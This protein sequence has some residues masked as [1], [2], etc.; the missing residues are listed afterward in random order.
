MYRTSIHWHGIRMHNNAINDGANGVTECPIPPGG[1][2]VYRFRAQQYGVTWY[3]SHYS[4][5]YANGVIGH[6]IINGPASLPFEND[7]GILSITDTYYQAADNILHRVNS[8]TDPIVP[9]APGAPPPADNL[10]F[11]GKAINYAGSGGS[12]AKLTMTRGKRHRLRLVNPSVDTSFTV[13]IVGHQMTVI[14]ADFVPVHSFT[15]QTLFLGIGQRYDVTIDASQA[16]GN[17]WI[18]AT[19]GPGPCG[20]SRNPFPAAI[21]S[22]QGAPNTLPTNRGTPPPN[23]RCEDQHGLVPVIPRNIPRGGFTG[24]TGQNIPVTL[25]TPPPGTTDPNARIVWK[26]N[27]SAIDIDWEHP[28]LELVANGDTDYPVKTNVISIPP[29][30]QVSFSVPLVCFL[31]VLTSGGAKKNSGATGSSRTKGHCRIPCIST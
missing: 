22:Y 27:G 14:A 1:R 21:L 19:L 18:N 17:Y 10:L 20:T 16:V 13:S 7:L 3:H 11:N 9:G 15:T 26:V 28:T 4:A 29:G 31:S 30:S 5:Q 8:L 24:A 2:L 6:V 25:V 12:Y 23:A